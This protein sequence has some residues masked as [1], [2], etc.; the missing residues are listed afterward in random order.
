MDEGTAWLRALQIL[1]GLGDRTDVDER[2]E[3]MALVL[4]TTFNE[5]KITARNDEIIRNAE[6]IR[7]LESIAHHPV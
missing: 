3:Y 7:R 2:E 6:M 5:G 4:R 1:A